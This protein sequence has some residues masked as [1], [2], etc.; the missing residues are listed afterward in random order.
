MAQNESSSAT[1]NLFA[2]IS[3]TPAAQSL[4]RRLE[5]GGVLSC[6]GI[7]ASAQPFF[8]VLL[9]QIFPNRPIVIVTENLKT[10][11]S[12]QQDL[13]TWTQVS[14]SQSSTL[15]PQL[16]FYPA[17]EIFP[18]E[19]KL[20]HADIISDR[21]Q[22]LV[23]LSSLSIPNSQPS[24][25]VVTS[26]TALLQ[27]TFSPG[28]I[29]ER[30]RTLTR[31]NKIAPLDLI[32]WL[33]EQGYEPEAQVSQKGEI[34][35]RGG[36]LDVFPPTSPWPVRLEFFGDELESLREFD[37]LAQISRGEI[38]EIVI[39]PAGELGILKNRI[40][41]PE[42]GSRN[43]TALST[44][45]DCLPRETLFLLCEPEQLTLRA[46]EYAQQIPADDPFFISWPD[47]FVEL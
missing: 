32:E 1:G 40:Q 3:L 23:A 9:R 16:F 39:P 27:R 26:V 5:N 4:A 11:E 34:A 36:I 46:D 19:G 29:Q 12:F 45:L 28:E 43:E 38:L 33:E 10:Q 17:W 15:N 8:A 20:P 31:G 2:D 14:I 24:T 41:K 13:E 42:A 18:H 37:P 22:T 7:C 30:T 44:L 25:L 6:T 35:L 21:L 47:F